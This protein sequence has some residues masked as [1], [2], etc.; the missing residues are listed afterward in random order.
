LRIPLTVDYI[1]HPGNF[2]LYGGL[3]IGLCTS[4]LEDA[5]ITNKDASCRVNGASSLWR[6]CI[7][8]GQDNPFSAPCGCIQ[9]LF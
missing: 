3:G 1:V 9:Y 5:I 7:N 2:D 6:C 8:L 4:D